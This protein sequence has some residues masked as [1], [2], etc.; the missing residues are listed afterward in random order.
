MDCWEQFSAI[1]AW[2]WQDAELRAVHFLTVACYNLQH[3]AK[4]EENTIHELKAA[5]LRHLDGHVSVVRIRQ[6][7]S[8]RFDGKARVL[9]NG[10]PIQA[11]ARKWGMTVADVYFAGRADGAARRV[12]DWA[13]VISKEIVS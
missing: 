3:P 5:F 10:M 8:E 7:M 4:F 12:K 11:A 1:L 2:E 6:L 13:A 9:R